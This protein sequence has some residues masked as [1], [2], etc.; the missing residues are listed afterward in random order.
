MSGYTDDALAPLGVAPG[1]I[2]FL[3]KPF[4][5]RQ[6]AERVRDA[7]DSHPSPL[8]GLLPADAEMA[9][10]ADAVV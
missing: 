1:D 2:A 7:L 3:D 10:P 4:T 8:A 6:L 5:P 9:L